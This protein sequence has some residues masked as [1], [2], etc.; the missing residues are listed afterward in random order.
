MKT[1]LI[2]IL[3]VQI[4]LSNAFCQRL[5]TS[6]YAEYTVSGVQYGGAAIFATDRQWGA[7]IFYQTSLSSTENVNIK[8]YYGLTLQV[9]IVRTSR[10]L[11]AGT[12]RS[13]V[14]NDQFF[15]I[16]PGLETQIELSKKIALAVGMSVRM[17]YPAVSSKFIIKLF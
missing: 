11:L 1:T 14:V 16:V 5:L 2:I 8:K 6:T 17:N 4:G 9:P 10:L 7:G 12:L 3:L 15:V 13:G